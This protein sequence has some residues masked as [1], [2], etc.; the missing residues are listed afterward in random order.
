MSPVTLAV[1]VHNHRLTCR[2]HCGPA[3]TSAGQK[4]T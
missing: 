4:V 2:P 1:V 3:E